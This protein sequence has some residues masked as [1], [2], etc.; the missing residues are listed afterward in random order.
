MKQGQT[1]L[2]LGREL[3]RQRAV[4][5]DFIADTHSLE[6]ETQDNKTLLSVCLDQGMEQFYL[7]DLA[8]QQIATRLQIPFRYYQ[9]MRDEYPSLLDENINCWFGKTPERR[10][11]RTLDNSVR[12]FLSDRYRRLDN[13]ELCEAVLPILQEMKGAELA[14][15]AVTD[16]H[17]YIKLINKRLKAEVGVGDVVQAGLVISNSEV[18]LGSLKVEPL[19]YRLACKNGMIVKDYA[20]KR[21]HVGRQV[22]SDDTAYEIYSNATLEADD[23]AFFLKVQDT[24]RCSVDKAKFMLTVDRLRD[25]KA[26]FTGSD[27]VKTVEVLADKYVLNQNERGGI[28]R[29]FIMNG[30]SSRYGLIQAVTRASQDIEDYGRATALERLG[31]EI[32]AVSAKKMLTVPKYS[33]NEENMKNVTPFMKRLEMA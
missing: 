22:D 12:A 18:G 4:R 32:L 27:P 30:D 33:I 7:N 16:T 31:G 28:L 17:L 23:R 26:D 19:V 14:S 15:C 1:L 9:K 8:H 5:K 13:L 3:E 29:H 25:A 24:V 6:V 20:Q 21:Y 11:I 10:M 2:E